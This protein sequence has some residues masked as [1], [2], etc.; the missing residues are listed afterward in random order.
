MLWY[1]CRYAYDYIINIY[2]LKEKLSKPSKILLHIT[3][4]PDIVIELSQEG[5]LIKEGDYKLIT[6]NPPPHVM[7][8]TQVMRR[9]SRLANIVRFLKGAEAKI[10]EKDDILFLENHEPQVGDIAAVYENDTVR[11]IAL[12][13]GDLEEGKKI[14]YTRVNSFTKMVVSDINARELL[15]LIKSK[16]SST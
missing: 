6:L 4:K 12:Y 3:P 7:K 5:S 1:W 11:G 15:N 14:F 13:G 16:T 2:Y 9:L 8:R 10:V